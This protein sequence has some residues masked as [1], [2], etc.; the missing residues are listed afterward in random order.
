M[1]KIILV[2]AFLTF[3][4]S[5]MAQENLPELSLTTVSGEKIKLQDY[6]SN[7]K[8]TVFAFW[9]TWCA[10]CKKELNNIAKCALYSCS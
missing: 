2:V 5:V 3:G 4:L 7:G 1:N 9:A 10:P 6:A 8:N